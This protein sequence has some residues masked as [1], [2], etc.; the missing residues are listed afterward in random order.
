MDILYQLPFPKEVCSKIFMYAC[1]SPH[2]GLGGSILKKQLGTDD[3]NIHE[4]DEDV[5]IFDANSYEITNSLD[6][7]PHKISIDIYYYT[8]FYNL[9][10]INLYDT[11]V[12]G[13]I[14]NLN[15]L[16]KLTEIWLF[17]TGV[18]G[19]ILHLASLLNLTT[20]DI[21]NTRVTG[22]IVH[23]KSLPNLS[24]IDLGN[25]GVS[26]DILHLNSLPNLSYIDLYVTGVTGN[27]AYLKSLPNLT[28]IVLGQTGVTGELDSFHEYRE[29]EGLPYCDI[30]L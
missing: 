10:V 7:Y 4:K 9:M 22:D 28:H 19:D 23:L 3:L 20:I 16:P 17:N 13:D 8:C 25:T 12:T 5:I 29:S 21:Y 27:V 14:I 1:K 26:G 6:D 2:T 24:Y 15:A 30:Y 11:C 18:T